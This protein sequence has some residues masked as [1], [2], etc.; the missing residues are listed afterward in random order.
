MKIYSKNN[1]EL[2]DIQV[3]DESYRYREIMGTPVLTLYFRLN[4]FTELPV[5]AYA[6]FQG[7]RFF[8]FD[9]L[10][11]TKNS[12]EDFNHTLVLHGVAENLSRFRIFDFVNGGLV[13]TLTATPADHIAMLVNVLNVK[14]SG[15]TAGTVAEQGEI[16]VNY[17]HNSCMEAL[18]MICDEAETEFEITSDKV[19]HLRKTEYN[20]AAPLEMAYGQGN[21]LKPGV[22]RRNDD[23][24]RPVERL[25]VQGGTRNI[26][27]SKYGSRYLLLPDN[28]QLIYQGRTY[29]VDPGGLFIQRADKPLTTGQEGSLD[30]SGIYPSRIC[31][32]SE[33]EV[34]DFDNNLFNIIDDSI[35]ETLNFEDQR[36]TGQTMNIVFQTGILT[37]KEFE[38]SRYNHEFRSFEIIPKE[39]DSYTMPGGV[40]LPEAGDTFVVFGCSFPDAYIRDDDTKTGA[41]WDM[42]REGVAYMYNEEEDKYSY[43]GSV[44]PVWLKAGW[45]TISPKL[46]LGGYCSLADPELGGVLIRIRSIKDYVNN[47]YDVEVDLSNALV[48]PSVTSTLAKI[49]SYTA[50]LSV[51][52]LIEAREKGI[53][54]GINIDWLTQYIRN[55]FP[56]F[57][58]ITGS[59][60]DN[61]ELWE[62]LQQIGLNGYIDTQTRLISGAVLWKQGMTYESTEL[63]YK[64]LGNRYTCP[65]TE[66]ALGDSHP[67]LARID[68][69]Y[70]DTYSN[71]QVKTGTPSANPLEPVLGQLELYVSSVFIGA[72]AT[73]PS[74]ISM[75]KIYDEKTVEEWTPTATA[76]S[77]KTTI[78]LE[79]TADPYTGIKHIEIEISVPD[80][81][82][83]LPQHYIGE[84]YQGGKIFWI[85]RNDS[86]KGLIAAEF[87]TVTDVMWSR[88]SDGGPYGTGGRGMDFY[89]GIINTALMLENK[90]SK[91]QAARWVNELRTGGYSDWYIGSEKEMYVLWMFRNIIGNFNPTK[92]YWTSTESAWDTARRV[93]WETGNIISRKKNTRR[94]VRAIRKFDDSLLPS[95]TPVEAFVPEETHIIFQAPEEVIAAEGIV[96]FRMKTNKP[97]RDNSILRLETYL[98][99]VRTGSAAISP[100]VNMFGFNQNDNENYQLTAVYHA[101]FAL[102]QNRFD[103]LKIDL[104]GTW[105][106]NFVMRLDSIRFQ[107]TTMLQQRA[108][109]ST[110]QVQEQVLEMEKWTKQLYWEYVW[111]NPNIKAT[112]IVEIVPHKDD[113]D[114]VYEAGILPETE[115]S[116]GQVKIFALSQPANDI[117][118]S[119]NITEGTL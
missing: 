77:G 7:Q 78:N 91:G 113:L 51:Q 27:F 26:D 64:I 72:G 18:G 2:L 57:G 102:S 88:L 11:F 104:T 59:P 100:K 23:N 112:S 90:S 79:E 75:Q 61:Q 50:A 56:S 29:Q 42:F 69:F 38:I 68:V 46:I 81:E 44:S 105:P 115:S 119:V 54:D 99:A 25:Y 48:K 93:D 30:A 36:I 95:S 35:P 110:L 86:R 118:I 32:V 12:S 52:Q 108:Q 21:G 85:D 5:G 83:S 98:G 15:W 74:F 41:S 20:K 24:K 28:Q 111:E 71:L 16:V 34:V 114:L 49:N 13:F 94:N 47:P 80:E 63:I 1:I 84:K 66:I 45:I 101:N 6:D 58:D 8:L 14:D 19:I 37:G 109:G 76:E 82:V 107:H 87:D 103:A 92:D 40:F 73:E 17:N 53:I 96:S 4:T 3:S 70:L 10:N 55:Y 67:A 33:L 65:P 116:A 31:T 43:G 60:Y 89:D 62:F 9:T 22:E 117:S 106:N 39:I 97:W